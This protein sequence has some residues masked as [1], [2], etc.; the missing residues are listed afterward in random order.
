[1]ESYLER[2]SKSIIQAMAWGYSIPYQELK[3]HYQDYID[4]RKELNEKPSLI[5]FSERIKK[6]VEELKQKEKDNG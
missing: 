1:M 2:N 4:K 3:V 5:D 6:A